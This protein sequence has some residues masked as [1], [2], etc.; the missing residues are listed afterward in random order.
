MQNYSDRLTAIY[1]KLSVSSLVLTKNP[2][3][4]H[5]IQF[6][7][8]LNQVRPVTDLE[9]S[10]SEVILELHKCNRRE[11]GNYIRTIDKQHYALLTDGTPIAGL[12]GIENI[13]SVK[14]SGQKNEYIVIA[15]S[16][17]TTGEISSD[18]YESSTRSF[19]RG[20]RPPIKSIGSNYRADNK[21]RARG[22]YEPK[23]QP[24]EARSNNTRRDTNITESHSM[25]VSYSRS[26]DKSTD[27]S[28]DK[29]EESNMSIS[30]GERS[31]GEKPFRERPVQE[32]P[33]RNDAAK[34]D[35]APTDT[36]G[37]KPPYRE[38]TKIITRDSESKKQTQVP[39]GG[40][41]PTGVLPSLSGDQFASILNSV[42]AS[43]KNIQEKDN[44][45]PGMC[46][47]DAAMSAN[48]NEPDEAVAK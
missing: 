6:A 28:S 32:R 24:Y 9:K 39:R 17:S 18:S 13:V 43:K 25:S 8:I 48:W 23:I 5:I 35:T 33:H 27:K 12:F 42:K 47:K 22:G 40:R 2:T 30:L 36:R 7:K 29:S 26:A 14:W 4:D 41:K 38:V 44:V 21:P 31:A 15:H 16:T 10:V 45:S 20:G 3:Y 19:E 34:V 37:G 11:F 46:A 1:D